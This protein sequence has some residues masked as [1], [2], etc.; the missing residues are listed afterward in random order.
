VDAAEQDRVLRAWIDGATYK[1]LLR[2]WRFG[3]AGDPAFQGE[4]GKHY[5]AVMAKRKA[6]T[7]PE[8]A[9]RASKD[10][11]WERP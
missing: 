9:V 1:Q 6:E 5:A 3:K 11:G 7:G 10:I 8:A 2:R 4:I